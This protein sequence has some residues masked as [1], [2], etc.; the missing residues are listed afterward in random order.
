M[1]LI[2][3][4]VRGTSYADTPF[5]VI[6]LVSVFIK[7]LFQTEI[8]PA[9]MIGFHAVR[10]R[11]TDYLRDQ[12]RSGE[13][14]ERGLAR[15]TGISQPHVHHILNGKRRLSL[16]GADIVL[17]TLHLDLLDLFTPEELSNRARRRP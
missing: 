12:V 17:E 2:L 13:A 16:E 5:A 8:L 15:T 11:L 10:Q 3:G 4:G 9:G 6:S 7:G 1:P 14:T